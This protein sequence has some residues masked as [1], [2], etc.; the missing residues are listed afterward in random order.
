MAETKNIKGGIQS[1]F[2][3]AYAD[4]RAFIDN[5]IAAKLAESKAEIELKNAEITRNYNATMQ[6]L[7]VAEQQEIAQIKQRY[8]QIRRQADLDKA[9]AFATVKTQ[10]EERVRG[11]LDEF[12]PYIK[13]LNT[14]GK[15]LEGIT[16]IER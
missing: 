14:A 2:Q 9:R 15:T 5:V 7:S 12:A 6:Q 4:T 13:D 10:V 11:S 3:K 1:I 16:A 8:E